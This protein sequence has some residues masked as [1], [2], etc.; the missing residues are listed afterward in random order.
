M[1]I[2]ACSPLCVSPEELDPAFV[3]K[4][5]EIAKEQLAKSG[6]P[7]NVLEKIIAGKLEKLYSEVCLLRQPYIKDDKR[8][9]QDILNDIIA[10]TGEKIVIKRF[11][12]FKVGA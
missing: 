1:Q 2:A 5:K 3:E 7:A 11:A 4:E 9:V 6:K 10:K 8:A 12:R